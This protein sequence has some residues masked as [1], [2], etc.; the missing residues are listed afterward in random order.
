M[1]QLKKGRLLMVFRSARGEE[2][3]QATEVCCSF[4]ETGEISGGEVIFELM[5]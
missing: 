2:Q 5:L 1:L 3:L 4:K